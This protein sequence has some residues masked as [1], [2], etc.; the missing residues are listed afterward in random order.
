MSRVIACLFPHGA[1]WVQAH[2]Y[3]EM[4]DDDDSRACVRALASDGMIAE[5]PEHSPT[6]DEARQGVKRALAE[7]MQ[8]QGLEQRDRHDSRP[9]DCWDQPY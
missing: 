8:A 1:R 6:L 9:S 5:G 7:W 2:G 3:T 4:T